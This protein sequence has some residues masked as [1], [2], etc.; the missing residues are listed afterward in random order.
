[1]NSTRRCTATGIPELGHELLEGHLQRLGSALERRVLVELVPDDR[2]VLLVVFELVLPAAA[3]PL[4]DLV[5]RRWFAVFEPVA[6]VVGERLVDAAADHHCGRLRLAFAEQIFA[7]PRLRFCARRFKFSLQ[8]Q[9][10]TCS[11]PLPFVRR[12]SQD[13]R[14]TTGRRNT[15]STN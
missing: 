3:I 7:P 11:R 12:R 8:L 5:H 15:K 10:E 4:Q 9:A 6:V 2:L 14:C 1:V 13:R